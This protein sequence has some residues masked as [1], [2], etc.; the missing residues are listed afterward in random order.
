MQIDVYEVCD[1]QLSHIYEDVLK[2]KTT[3]LNRQYF[4]HYNLINIVTCNANSVFSSDYS[5]RILAL[6]HNIYLK[7]TQYVC[8]AVIQDTSLAQTPQPLSARKSQAV[9]II[10]AIRLLY[11]TQDIFRFLLFPFPRLDGRLRRPITSF[12]TSFILY[13][14]S[15]QTRSEVHRIAAMVVYRRRLANN[16]SDDECVFFLFVQ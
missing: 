3:I 15:A 6:L 2:K 10:A 13:F 9:T 14:V 4:C 12:L 7:H 16:T 8:L 5:H 1:V 11:R